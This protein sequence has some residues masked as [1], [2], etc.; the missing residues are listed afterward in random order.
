[1]K[2]PVIKFAVKIIA[3]T[4]LA[5]FTFLFAYASYQE[6]HDEVPNGCCNRIKTGTGG[7]TRDTTTDLVVMDDLFYAEPLANQ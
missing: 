7:H 2:T 6:Y 1:M 3:I 4:E 5:L